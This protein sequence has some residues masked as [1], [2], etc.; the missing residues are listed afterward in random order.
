MKHKCKYLIK[1]KGHGK[2]WC[3]WTGSEADCKHC[4]ISADDRYGR[5]VSNDRKA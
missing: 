4:G 3:T 1:A 2:D 5:M